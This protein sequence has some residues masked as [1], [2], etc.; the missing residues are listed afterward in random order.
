MTEI[1]QAAPA[2]KYLVDPYEDWAK[3][4]GIPIHTGASIDLLA[5]DTRPWARFGGKGAFCHLEGR[6]DF[7]S[8]FLV[9]LPPNTS[10]A[11]QKHLYEE[12]CFVL[13]GSGATEIELA[14]GGK[15]TIEWGPK[16]L[17]AVP[18][19]ARYRHR[20]TSGAPAR[21][22]AVNDLR[23]MLGLYRSQKFI[24][25]VPA[26]FPERAGGT[27]LVPDVAALALRETEGEKG[28]ASASL[29]LSEG[30]IGADVVEIPSGIYRKARRQMQGSH[31][32]GVA[33]EGYTLVWEEGEQDFVR[34]DWRHGI[35]YAPPGMA[36]H[37]H[38][39]AGR[40][41]ARYLDLQLGSARYPMFRSRRAAYG[42]SEVYASGSAEIPY[43]AQD[44]RI[45]AI[46]L[47]AIAREGVTPGM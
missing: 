38:F 8:V 44:P 7:L 22:A 13:S 5:V 29:T 43:A 26:T 41:P 31:L 36:F 1:D 17:F 39:N 24:F 18:M 20:S 33:G 15:Q 30:S 4:E 21:L 16:S 2:G 19:N 35:V 46:W 27:N 11:P 14:D 37:Q 12:V 9:E 28:S 47:K 23:Y 45:H 10:S 42:D 3:G 32:F 34:T 40:N 6:C 25:N